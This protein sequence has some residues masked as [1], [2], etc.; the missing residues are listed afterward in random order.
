LP[1]EGLLRNISVTTEKEAIVGFVALLQTTAWKEVYGGRSTQNLT[2]KAAPAVYLGCNVRHESPMK[3][4]MERRIGGN[5]DGEEAVK[6]EAVKKE[7]DMCCHK[8]HLRSPSAK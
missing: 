5:L 1:S 6:K 3:D 4:R 8:V 7:A 2:D